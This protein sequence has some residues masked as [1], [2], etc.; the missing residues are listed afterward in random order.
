MATEGDDMGGGGSAADLLGGGGGDQQ[1]Q[2]QQQGDDQLQQQDIAGGA[3]PDWWGTLAAD[4]GD[5]D[6]PSNRDWIKARGTKTLDDLV[7]NARDAQ[8]AVRDGGRVKVPGEGATADEV[9]EFRK[10]VGVP[11]DA[12]GYTFDVPKD[13]A[14]NDLPLDTDL[15]GR[16]SESALKHG[17]PVGVFKGI[18]EDF[19]Q[20][21]LDQAAEHDT[22][23]KAIA[24]GIVKGWGASAAEKTAAID[25]SAK[26]LGLS[27]DDMVGIRNVLGS[28]RALGM[29]AK[30]G[31]GMS[32]DML[33]GG[34]GNKFGISGPEAAAEIQRLIQDKEF[35]TKLSAKDPAS[36]A[37]WDRLN[38]AQAE[39]EE[40]QRKA[41]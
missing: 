36:V 3:D 27:R 24:A 37:R 19:I 14:G 29:F 28:E 13:A 4:G 1:Q 22:A 20:A 15:L 23:E 18:V 21:Q 40:A 26:A 34:G 8:R 41:A 25:R 31:E 39:Y 12:K 5:A 10:A 30:L 6:N 33:L 32:E 11:D 2:Q 7:K 17:A 38:N 35:Q 16:L 9:A